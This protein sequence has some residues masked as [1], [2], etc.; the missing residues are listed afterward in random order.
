M[1]YYGATELGAAERL[2][3]HTNAMPQDAGASPQQGPQS[4]CSPLPAVGLRACASVSGP[5]PTI[6]CRGGHPLRSRAPALPVLGHFYTSPLPCALWVIWDTL[7]HPLL[8]LVFVTMP[9]PQ[10]FKH[11]SPFTMVVKTRSRDKG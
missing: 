4:A 3:T 1:G 7:H 6:C 9:S 5:F 10:Q 11:P 2:N 8:S